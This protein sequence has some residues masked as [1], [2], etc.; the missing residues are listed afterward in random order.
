MTVS[1]N[2]EVE[3]LAQEIAKHPAK[4]V[5]EALLLGVKDTMLY[6]VADKLAADVEARGLRPALRMVSVEEITAFVK[7]LNGTEHPAQWLI[8]T[9][10]HFNG[11]ANPKVIED[12]VAAV[13]EEATLSPVVDYERVQ[14]LLESLVG[15]GVAYARV[16]PVVEGQFPGVSRLILRDIIDEFYK[17]TPLPQSN[18]S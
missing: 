11:Q 3:A 15:C 10:R 17:T 2:P 18:G 6:V 8:K 7:T 12:V 9:I 16:L 13:R 5:V 14:R 4:T 1:P